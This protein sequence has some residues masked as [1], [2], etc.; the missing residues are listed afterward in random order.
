MRA[1]RII[2]LDRGRVVGMGRHAELMET[3]AVYREI[4]SSQLDT[5]DLA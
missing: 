4:A 5:E 3:C 1:D 2:V